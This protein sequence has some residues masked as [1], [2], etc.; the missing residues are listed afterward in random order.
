MEQMTSNK[1]RMNHKITTTILLGLLIAVMLFHLA[2][3]V[4][5]IP[6]DIA[7]SGRLRNDS[8]MYAFETISIG[9]NLFLTLVILMKSNYLKFQ[10][11][12]K[13]TDSILWFFL[14]LF[15]LNTLGNLVAKTIF[16]KAFAVITLVFA[17]LIL[18]ILKPNTQTKL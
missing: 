9:I 15:I 11:K 14:A 3:I 4:K 13:T 5:L 7:W 2:I 10:F 8:E 1:K 6:Y 18:K 12:E 16:E 17:L